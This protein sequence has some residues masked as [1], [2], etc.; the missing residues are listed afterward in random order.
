M[1]IMKP[2][3]K[4]VKKP[5]KVEVVVEP[6]EETTTEDIKVEEEQLWL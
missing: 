6:V 4:K 1:K 5:K 3:P 2:E